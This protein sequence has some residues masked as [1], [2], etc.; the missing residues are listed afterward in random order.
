MYNF[1]LDVSSFAADTPLRSPIKSFSVFNVFGFP[2]AKSLALLD[3]VKNRGKHQNEKTEH[4]RN[5]KKSERFQGAGFSGS[6]G[7][8]RRKRLNEEQNTAVRPGKR[9]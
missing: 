9:L 1:S 6:F 2:A 3:W 8:V 7:Q 4:D 5:R